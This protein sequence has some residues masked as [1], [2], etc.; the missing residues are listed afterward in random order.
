MLLPLLVA[1]CVLYVAVSLLL[2]FSVSLVWLE[3]WLEGSAQCV[4]F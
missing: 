1:V 3:L 2:D 4:V